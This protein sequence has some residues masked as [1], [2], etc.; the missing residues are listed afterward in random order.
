MESGFFDVMLLTET[1][2]QLEVY[3]HN[4][5]GYDVTCS[6]ACPSSARLDKGGVGLVIRERPV[7]WGIDS[8]RYHGP[9]VVRCKIATG[10]TWTLLVRAYLPLLTL[11]HLPDF[12]KAL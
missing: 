7:E 6:A 5:L 4:R 11:N 2:I 3:S 1:K 9:N 10:L 8:T 12:E